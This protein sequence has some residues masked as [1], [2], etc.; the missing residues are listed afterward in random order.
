MWHSILRRL[1]ALVMI[2]TGLALLYAA[3][4]VVCTGIW[5]QWGESG[6]SL[7]DGSMILNRVWRGNQLYIL[8]LLYGAIGLGAAVWGLRV[9]RGSRRILSRADSDSAS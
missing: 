9:W 3:L 7:S 1:L 5:P 4:W 8:V 2:S 6:W